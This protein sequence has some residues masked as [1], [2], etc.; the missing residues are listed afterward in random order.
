MCFLQAKVVV[1]VVVLHAKVYEEVFL[2]LS[3]DKND[4]VINTFL[5]PFVAL[6]LLYFLVLL[7]QKPI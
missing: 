5:H 6:S 3:Q 4:G 2:A 7:N 1:K